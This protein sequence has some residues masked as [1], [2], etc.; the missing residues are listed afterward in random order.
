MLSEL[1]LAKD[2]KDCLVS[3]FLLLL[4]PTAE[5]C[6]VSQG[7]KRTCMP[8]SLS[9]KTYVLVFVAAVPAGYFITPSTRLERG[10]E[11]SCDPSIAPCPKN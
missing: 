1:F 6:S 2:F 8:S 4:L 5:P 11:L 9:S 7:V 3:F 10:V